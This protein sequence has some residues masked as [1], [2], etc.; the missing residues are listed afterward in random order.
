[1]VGE[2]LVFLRAQPRPNGGQVLDRK[3]RESLRM[4]QVGRRSVALGSEIE[5]HQQDCSHDCRTSA[6]ISAKDGFGCAAQVV[7]PTLV[8]GLLPVFYGDRICSPEPVDSDGNLR[9]V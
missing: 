8:V 1:M 9:R 2:V 4:A 3:L 6:R 7:V 5:A